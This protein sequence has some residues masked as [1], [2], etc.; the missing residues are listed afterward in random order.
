MDDGF[1]ER[2]G[3]ARSKRSVEI[4][5]QRARHKLIDRS[6]RIRCCGR[7]AGIGFDKNLR[8]DPAYKIAR[9]IDRDRHHKSDVASRQHPCAVRGRAC[10]GANVKIFR[11]F[12]RRDDGTR[13]GAVI[14]DMKRGRQAPGIEIY[15]EAEQDELHQRHTHHHGEGEPV[16][17]HLN[18]FLDQNRISARAR[19]AVAHWTT[20][21][22][23]CRSMKTSSRL[24]GVSPTVIPA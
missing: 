1:E 14:G 12:Q 16:P 15:S 23:P 22:T 4:V 11:I 6:K 24:G 21:C 8:R 2:S 5:L 10:L 9:E 18:E 13:I 3:G 19:E 7:I 17:A 20:G